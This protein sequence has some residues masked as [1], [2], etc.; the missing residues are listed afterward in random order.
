MF[1]GKCGAKIENGDLFCVSCGAKSESVEK[2]NEIFQEPE[3]A[4][5]ASYEKTDDIKVSEQPQ[6]ATL[7]I[8]NTVAD[9]MPA[10]NGA[11]KEPEEPRNQHIPLTNKYSAPEALKAPK[12]KKR[13]GLIIAIFAVLLVLLAGSFAIITII[14]HTPIKDYKVAINNSLAEDANKIYETRVKDTDKEDSFIEEVKDYVDKISGD[15]KNKRTDFFVSKKILD[16]IVHSEVCAEYANNALK[17][18]SELN[19]SR[20]AFDRG[21]N[22]EKTPGETARALK[23]YKKVINADDNYEKAQQKVSELSAKCKQELFESTDKLVS[24]NNYDLANERLF[25]AFDLLPDDFTIQE[26]IKDVTTKKINYLKETQIVLAVEPKLTPKSTSTRGVVA[27]VK[28]NSD[29]AI[30]QVN[31]AFFAKDDKGNYLKINDA[32]YIYFANYELKIINPKTTT[33]ITSRYWKLDTTNE[34]YNKIYIL[35]ACI[36]QVEF[37][38]GTT[39]ENPYFDFWADEA[40]SNT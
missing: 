23:E 33:N 31:I 37:A 29:K 1:C 9:I 34:I 27:Q 32:F 30:K 19:S 38:D 40:E 14:S 22:Y 16:N 5:E 10:S 39:W 6:V 12:K 26:K 36:E 25:A 3:S 28:N 4:E 24:E 2:T 20:E 18:I 17:T 21:Q 13:I 8:S 15:F 11:Q 7:P 35:E